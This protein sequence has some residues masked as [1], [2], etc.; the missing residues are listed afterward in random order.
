MALTRRLCMENICSKFKVF[1]DSLQTKENWFR[2]G[3]VFSTK[4]KNYFFDTGT[5]KV[6]EISKPT[7]LA[8]D[9]ILRTNNFDNLS[10]LGLTCEELEEALQDIKTTVQE[11]NILKAPPVEYLISRAPTKDAL[12]DALGHQI[13]SLTLELT[14]KCNLR[15]KYCIY[16]DSRTD[17][18]NFE[19]HDMSIETVKKSIDFLFD[20]SESDVF[21]CFYGGEPLLKFDLIQYAVEYANKKAQQ[22][23]RKITYSMTSNM[24]LMDD[25]KSQYI[26]SMENF[27]VMA[28][29]DGPKEIHDL[30]RVTI[31]GEGSFE[32]AIGGVYRLVK[33][34][35]KNGIDMPI[36]FSSVITPPYTEKKFDE[37]Q[38][39][40]K[41]LDWL[42][43]NSSIQ[44]GYES[45]EPKKE[46]Y[47]PINSREENQ[48]GYNDTIGDIMDPLEEWS[49]AKENTDLENIFSYSYLSKG[50]AIIH[51]R[52]IADKPFP[53]Y[54]MH[55]CCI[56]G[57][58]KCYITVNGDILP[59]ERVGSIAAIGNV[60]TGYDIEK[61][62]ETYIE[63][64]SKEAVKYCSE[65]WAVNI[66]SDCYSGCMDKNGHV[67]FSYKHPR[68][69][70]T[71]K[72]IRY[73]LVCYHELLEHRPDVISKI[74]EIQMV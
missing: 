47:I 44:I 35:N 1:F 16:S 39:F 43:K 74:N 14:E 26:G 67:N 32:K 12:K 65:C 60:D 10:Q 3:T 19:T 23:N 46:L 52:K 50:F 73:D 33:A 20:H 56:P 57:G 63:E 55:G 18:R 64:Y 34:R 59:C 2:F 24:V 70:S 62:F 69:R 9:C 17:Y 61:I 22:L 30:N 49:M 31:N 45:R 41:S 53:Y 4:E 42:P 36:L 38:S 7:K 27:S 6:F 72:H 25:E 54:T 66:C 48:L 13:D 11:E 68:C 29:I 40:I 71:R 21:L 58:R 28:S 51:Q 8:L 37:I 5:G 15:C